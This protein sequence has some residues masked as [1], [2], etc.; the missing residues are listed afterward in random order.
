MS[1]FK[2]AAASE[3]LLKAATA[4]LVPAE[5]EA[6]AEKKQSRSS[7]KTAWYRILLKIRCILSFQNNYFCFRAQARHQ[8][9]GSPYS[10]VSNKYLISPWGQFWERVL[11]KHKCIQ[12][13]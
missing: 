12:N 3:P 11:L 13:L 5:A 7:G 4:M 9:P 10:Q 1:A 8:F 6:E 2:E